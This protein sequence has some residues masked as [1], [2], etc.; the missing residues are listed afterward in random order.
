MLLTLELLPLVL[1]TAAS[2]GDGRIIF[3]SSYGHY[4]AQAFNANTLNREE[5]D[6]S[7]LSMYNNT[8]LYNVRKFIFF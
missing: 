7:R 4:L 3:V 5:R 8:K 6:Y 2:T 1:D